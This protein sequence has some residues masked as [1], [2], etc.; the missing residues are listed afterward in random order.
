MYYA[1]K[2]HARQ[3]RAVSKKMRSL[4][5]IKSP[6]W[7]NSIYT[8]FQRV[9]IEESGLPQT[10]D[11]SEQHLTP[12]QSCTANSLLC[13]QYQPTS[14]GVNS[15]YELWQNQPCAIS[16]IIWAAALQTRCRFHLILGHLILVSLGKLRG[17][18]PPSK[19]RPAAS[20]TKQPGLPAVLWNGSSAW[21]QQQEKTRTQKH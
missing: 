5:G 2:G 12:Q 21:N 15:G 8:D 18:R 19:L 17:H 20:L 10:D 3:N 1:T 16:D 9:E 14:R 4:F 7:I 6:R 13:N 11:Q